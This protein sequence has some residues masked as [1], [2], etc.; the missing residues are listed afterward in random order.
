MII[1]DYP[2]LWHTRRGSII[3]DMAYCFCLPHCLVICPAKDGPDILA[4]GGGSINDT[5]AQHFVSE[6]LEE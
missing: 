2:W 5:M 4:E 1:D 3:V 6:G